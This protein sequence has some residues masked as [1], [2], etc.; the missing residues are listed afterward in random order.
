MLLWCHPQ[1][2][3]EGMMPNL[4]HV[5][6]VGNDTVLD[7]I[8]QSQNTPLALCF[9]ANVTVFLVHA[10]HDSR[11]FRTTYDGRE[12]SSGGIVAGETCLDHT[13]AIV[14]HEG[15]NFVFRR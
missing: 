4:F 7:G 5:I 11:H 13:A 8:F 9:I 15:R 6:P 2:V 1:L 12:D 10:N 14:A 3:V